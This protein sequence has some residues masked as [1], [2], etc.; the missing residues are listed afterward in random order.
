MNITFKIYPVKL[1]YITNTHVIHGPGL[2][3]LQG[4][5]IRSKPTRME[6]E[7]I[8]ISRYL[9][10]IKMFVTLTSDVIFLS[11]VNLLISFTKKKY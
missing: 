1:L 6:M 11:G 7:Q 4:K 10:E 5:K 9:Y 3:G 8:P 2:A